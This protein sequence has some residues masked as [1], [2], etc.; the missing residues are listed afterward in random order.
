MHIKVSPDKT[1]KDSTKST[2]RYVPEVSPTDSSESTPSGADSVEKV[3]ESSP[4]TP[5]MAPTFPPSNPYPPS[6]LG[7]MLPETS[8]SYVP[9]FDHQTYPNRSAEQD[10]D[11]SHLVKRIDVLEADVH[12]QTIYNL[13]QN[14]KITLFGKNANLQV[15]KNKL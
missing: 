15:F 8:P 11:I 13:L 9:E 1:E 6:G 4:K 2:P 3:T 14:D 12:Y 10:S 5:P 7:G